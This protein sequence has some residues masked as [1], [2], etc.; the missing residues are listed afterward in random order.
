MVESAGLENRN[1]ACGIE[2][3]NPSPSAETQKK[4]DTNVRLSCFLFVRRHV[5]RTLE[6]PRAKLLCAGTNEI[7][8]VFQEKTS[9]GG[10]LVGGREGVRVVEMG[11]FLDITWCIRYIKKIRITYQSDDLSVCRALERKEAGNAIRSTRS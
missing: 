1:T 11:D 9:P 10:A 4:P 8:E 2:G 3:S 6:I 7:D 5:S